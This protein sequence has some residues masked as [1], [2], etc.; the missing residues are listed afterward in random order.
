MT[1]KYKPGS[2]VQRVWE[3]YEK[4]GAEAATKFGATLALAPTTLKSWCRMW[5][6]G[7]TR[8]SEASGG[9]AKR[10]PREVLTPEQKLEKKNQLIAF[11]RRRVHC[12][13]WPERHGTL[14]KEGPEVSEIRWDEGG[15]HDF[16]PNSEWKDIEDVRATKPKRNKAADR[17]TDKRVR[18]RA[19]LSA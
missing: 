14:I 12:T 1:T 6:K 4:D 16:I 5:A 7:Q 8:T 15:R 17:D 10:E 19:A 18:K 13:W 2:R 3:V 11:G 9:G